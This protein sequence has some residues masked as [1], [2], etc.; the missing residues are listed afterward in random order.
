MAEIV[1]IEIEMATL[2][3]LHSKGVVS[4]NDYKVKVV[5]EEHDYTADVKWQEL[6]KK[7]SKAY[8]ELKSR[9]FELRHNM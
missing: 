9:E 3:E 5:D 8:R 7:S 2:K 6:K 1:T 4:S